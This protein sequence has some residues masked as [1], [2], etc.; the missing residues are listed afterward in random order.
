M[1]QTQTCTNNNPVHHTWNGCV[2]SRKPVVDLN[3]TASF[4]TPIPGLIDTWCNA[5]LVRLTMDT[6]AIKAQV[7]GLWAN[8]E[9]YI[10]AGLMWGWRVL[11]P[12]PPFADGV[13]ASTN[14][15]TRKIMV[16]MT[17]GENTK[18]QIDTNHEGGDTVASDAAMAS[19]C[20]S[21]KADNIDLYMIAFTVTNATTK[22]RLQACASDVGHFYDAADGP[23]LQH[24]FQQI[25]GSLVKLSLSR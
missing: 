4:S 10:A 20:T 15:P 24:A 18:S 2:G 12:L 8:G 25:G 16:L 22:A 9:T 14:P 1:P 6:S 23:A 17:D 5:P 19:L 3:V 7:D 11:T 13:G 21:I